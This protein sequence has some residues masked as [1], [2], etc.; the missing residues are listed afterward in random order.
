MDTTFKTQFA[1]RTIEYRPL[2]PGQLLAVQMLKKPGVEGVPVRALH[3]LFRVLE[4]S[5]GADE[6]ATIEDDMAAGTV[7]LP[8]IMQLAVKIVERSAKQPDA[9]TDVEG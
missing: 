1:G 2:L 9:G 8:A 6:W 4:S 7:D 5:V 3:R